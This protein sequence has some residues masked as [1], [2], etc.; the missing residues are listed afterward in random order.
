VNSELRHLVLIVAVS[1]LVVPIVSRQ[2]AGNHLTHCKSNLKNI[3]TALEMYA[4]DYGG[5]YPRSLQAL[6]PN[7]LKALPTCPITGSDYTDTYRVSTNPD[8]FSFGCRGRHHGKPDLDHWQPPFDH[9]QGDPWYET[10][11]GFPDHPDGAADRR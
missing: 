2:M 8:G 10:S 1:A 6:P 5:R 3:A 7:Y 9:T 4:S 11:S